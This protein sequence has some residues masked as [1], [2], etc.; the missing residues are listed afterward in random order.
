MAKFRWTTLWPAAAPLT[1]A[2]L[3]DQ[4]GKVFIVTGASGGLGKHLATIL[5][6]RNAKVYLAARAVEKTAA[7]MDEIRAAHPTSTGTLVFLRLQL[8]DLST[9]KASAAEFLSKETR[10][11]VL[12]NNAGVMVPPSGSKTVQGYELQYGTNC[13]GTMLFTS[14][15]RDIL[16]ATAKTAPKNSVRVIWVSSSAADGAPSP[17]IDYTNM[18][19]QRDENRWV[20][21]CRSKAGNGLHAAEFARR[22]EGS[23]VLSF[24][25]NPGNYMTDLQRSNSWLMRQFISLFTWPPINGAYTELFAGLDTSIDEKTTWVVPFGKV[26]DSRE[27]LMDPKLG[28]EFWQWSEEQIKPYV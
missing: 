5:Y 26:E 14:C 9:I 19:Y 12:W 1:E 20:K 17:P 24:A 13:L 2:N 10:L 23:G 16:V 4:D 11:D 22:T 25:L 18:D 27:D 6:Q 28:E 8:D 3:P 21:Y 15:L 7:V